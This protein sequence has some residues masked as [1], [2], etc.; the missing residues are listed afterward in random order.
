[1][2]KRRALLVGI[3][4]NGTS[5]QL[6]G[7]IND[8]TSMKAYMETKGYVCTVLTDD[9]EV[10]PTRANILKY[11]MELILSDSTNLF[12]HYSGH[13]ASIA[14]TNRDESDGKDETLCPLDYPTAGLIVDDEIRGILNSLRAN[15]NLFAV[16]D[17]CH[18]GTGMDLAYNLFE[19]VS[20]QKRMLQDR[21]RRGVL[22][23]ETR[24]QVVM[25]SGCQDPQTSADAWINKK[26]QG[27]M[28]W[29]TLKAFSDIGNVITY[30]QLITVT[31]AN[32]KEGRYE[33][34]PNLAC[35][36]ALDLKCKIVL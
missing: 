33:Q 31:R 16:L 9:T 25:L 27:A 12:F 15:Q 28:T 4:Y 5:S 17:C 8:V 11:F 36:K 10:K 26:A 24:G 21:N 32:L 23:R 34:L 22:A 13:G 2:I 20:G 6:S 3:N 35:G 30:E 14:D 18:S 1:M 19:S 7:C 29:A